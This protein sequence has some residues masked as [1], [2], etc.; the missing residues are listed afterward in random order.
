MMNEDLI[1]ILESRIDNN[2]LK[3]ILYIYDVLDSSGYMEIIDAINNLG[4]I[5]EIDIDTTVLDVKIVMYL[6]RGLLEYFRNMGII[7]D[8]LVLSLLS[9]NF[10]VDIIS[11][12]K[13][14]SILDSDEALN[15][16][17]NVPND[18]NNSI[19]LLFYYVSSINPYIEDDKFF[20]L[21]DDVYDGTIEAITNKL[22]ERSQHFTFNKIKQPDI[23]ILPIMNFLVDKKIRT[24][25][26]LLNEFVLNKKI[27]EDKIINNFADLKSYEYKKL[28]LLIIEM[29]MDDKIIIQSLM[30]LIL[31]YFYGMADS[32]NDDSW[33]NTLLLDLMDKIDNNYDFKTKLDEIINLYKSI[34]G[35]LVKEDMNDEKA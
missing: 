13:Q 18:T 26:D 20:S 6:R 27:T 28:K 12:L 23:D 4:N 34:D 17:E 3:N 29:G 31:I 1:R 8:E 10:I 35:M 2:T 25:P 15:I 32:N 5:N 9:L 33:Y 30:S 11:S 21:I 24:L 22:E 16:L 19:D 14:I 7:C